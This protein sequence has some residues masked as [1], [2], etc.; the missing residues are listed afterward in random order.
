VIVA[1]SCGEA[2]EHEVL[3]DDDWGHDCIVPVVATR[4]ALGSVRMG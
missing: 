3:F 2:G 4:S 1:R